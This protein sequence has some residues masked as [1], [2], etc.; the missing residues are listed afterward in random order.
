[1]NRQNNPESRAENAETQRRKA[2]ECILCSADSYLDRRNLQGS[3]RVADCV[4]ARE[5]IKVTILMESPGHRVFILAGRL[6]LAVLLVAGVASARDASDSTALGQSVIGSTSPNELVGK[7]IQNELQV[8]DEGRFM[9]RDRRQTPDG[10]KT[11]EMIETNAGVVALLLAVNDQPL[12]PQQRNEEAARLHYLADHPEL[13]K[14]KHKEQQ[15]D[16]DQV[17][18]LFRELPRAFRYQYNGMEPGPDDA[19]I[20]LTFTPDPNYDPPSRECAV[21][22]GM[23]GHMSVAVPEYRL[24]S[25]EATLFQEVNFG[26]GVLGH[27]DKGGHFLVQQSKIGP[28]RWEATS[29]NT[30]FTGKILLFKSIS[31]HEVEALSDFQPVPDNLSLEQGISK[32]EQQAI[33]DKR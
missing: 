26:W 29:M 32:V 23:S 12:T 16:E 14:Q 13:Q 3:L 28:H 1:M 27:L 15:K 2:I 17:K 9:Y 4:M 19:I 18:R 22:K 30:Q 24:V 21:Y 25:I 33:S 5:S 20:K 7:V 31:L 6:V 11:K 8:H 10:S